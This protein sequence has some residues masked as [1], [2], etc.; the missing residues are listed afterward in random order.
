MAWVGVLMDIWA[1]EMSRAYQRV[2]I[3]QQTG[4]DKAAKKHK[5]VDSVVRNSGRSIR[6]Q[7]FSLLSNALQ[8]DGNDS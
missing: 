5:S 7:I 6:G 2:T 8:P 4:V 1:L 3:I